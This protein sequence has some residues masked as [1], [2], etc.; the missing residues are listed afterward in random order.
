L[1]ERLAGL[2]APRGVCAVAASPLT[3]NG[4]V[5]RKALPPPDVNR[6][7]SGQAH[8]SP[9]TPN[10][11]ALAHI[12]VEVLKITEVGI[13]DNFF[14]LGGHSLLAVQVVSRIRRQLDGESL[15]S[16]FEHQTIETLAIVL[17]EKQVE[18]MV[19]KGWTEAR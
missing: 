8:Q 19:L 7:H 9:R 10:E 15:R 18:A 13:Q 16:I 4:K 5:D 11:E 1:R 14:D 12:W 17:L 3:P 6:A 2:H